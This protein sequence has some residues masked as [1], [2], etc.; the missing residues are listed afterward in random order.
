MGSIQILKRYWSSHAA[1]V[2]VRYISRPRLRYC[3]WLFV[4]Y[5]QYKSIKYSTIQYNIIHC[6]RI[7]YNTAFIWKLS[8]QKCLW[9]R[10]S[11]VMSIFSYWPPTV[12]LM[13]REP[14]PVIK[15]V[16]HASGQTMLTCIGSYFF[17]LIK[18]L[19][20]SIKPLQS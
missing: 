19:A 5:V 20:H 1:N 3:F 12:R 11:R 6:N 16:K 9:P 17:L 14:S 8:I 13:L 18:F 15:A 2:P 7:Q 10:G 4:K